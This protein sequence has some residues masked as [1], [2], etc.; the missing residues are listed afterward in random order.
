M[1][2]GEKIY[3]VVKLAIIREKKPCPL[4]ALFKKNTNQHSL[5]ESLL[6]N[7]STKLFGNRQDTL[8]GENF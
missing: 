2:S 3:K 8:K 7:I 1:F 4:A 5:K 6:K